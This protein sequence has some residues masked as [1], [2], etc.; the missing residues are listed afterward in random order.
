[1][2]ENLQPGAYLRVNDSGDGLVNVMTAPIDGGIG[3]NAKIRA[4][5]TLNFR[6]QIIS[7]LKGQWPSLTFCSLY[8]RG[9]KDWLLQQDDPSSTIRFLKTG[10]GAL[11]TAA[12]IV[13]H[14]KEQMHR[15]SK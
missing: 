3:D 7:F 15:Y 4:A 13:L 12:Q 14:M 9:Y 1:M 8:N 5:H 10:D 11:S 2:P 6:Y